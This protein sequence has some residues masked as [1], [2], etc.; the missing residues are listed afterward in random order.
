[1]APKTP[2][3]PLAKPFSPTAMQAQI[4]EL[5]AWKNSSNPEA[6][7]LTQ[8]EIM[9]RTFLQFIKAVPNANATI[10]GTITVTI[11]GRQ[12]NLLYY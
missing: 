12:Y 6:P 5:M 7:G 4:D 2:K 9:R 10:S 8:E 11:S 3:N 1:M